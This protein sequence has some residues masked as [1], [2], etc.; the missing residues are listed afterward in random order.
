ML[1]EEKLT[2]EPTDN[3]T[4]GK[5]FYWTL[6][7]PTGYRAEL[8]HFRNFLP[9][10]CILVIYSKIELKKMCFSFYLRVIEIWYVLCHLKF[11]ET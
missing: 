11:T 8:K 7:P 6:L 4:P 2:A 1:Q 3:W 9:I 5:E 10:T